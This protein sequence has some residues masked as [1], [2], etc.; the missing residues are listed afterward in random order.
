LGVLGNYGLAG[1]RGKR[2]QRLNIIFL[3]SHEVSAKKNQSLTEASTTATP[4]Q[5]GS[6]SPPTSR[7]RSSGW[8]CST[9]ASG[10]GGGLGG[11]GTRWR[12]NQQRVKREAE[13]EVKQPAARRAAAA[14][15]QQR[16]RRRR[17]RRHHS[18]RS[19]WLQG[20]W[21]R[22]S[23]SGSSCQRLPRMPALSWWCPR[24]GGAPTTA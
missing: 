14:R 8:R 16:R 15:Q 5:A 2:Q 22:T 23:T 20:A 3:W 1:C 17:R 18:S 9:S 12:L 11:R 24:R 10:C 13:R 21:R 7:R 4:P 6:R 19:W